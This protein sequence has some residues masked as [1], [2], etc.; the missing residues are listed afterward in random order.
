LLHARGQVGK[1]FADGVVSY[2]LPTD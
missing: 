1:R 2:F